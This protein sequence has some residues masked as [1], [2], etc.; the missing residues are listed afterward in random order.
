MLQ[1]DQHVNEAPNSHQ[2]RYNLTIWFDV[3]INSSFA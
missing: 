2:K 3:I 1:T